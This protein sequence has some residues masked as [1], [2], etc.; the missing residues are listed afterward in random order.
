[1]DTSI[2]IY[3]F[4]WGYCYDVW[5]DGRQY[6]AVSDASIKRLKH[7]VGPPFGFGNAVCWYAYCP[8]KEVATTPPP[9]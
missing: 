8:K 6:N 1:M 9:P 7:V 2:R 4:N 3:I 5:I